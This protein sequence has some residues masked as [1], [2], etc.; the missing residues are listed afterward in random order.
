MKLQL[1]Y[2]SISWIW[3]KLQY[4]SLNLLC[5]KTASVAQDPAIMKP[6]GFGRWPKIQGTYTPL[7]PKVL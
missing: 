2:L 4:W 5:F 6:G 1:P 3:G 7:A